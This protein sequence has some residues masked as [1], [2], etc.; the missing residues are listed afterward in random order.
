MSGFS[1]NMQ[2]LSVVLVL[3]IIA[4]AS[5]IVGSPAHAQRR[6]RRESNANRKARIER[7]IQETYSH[8]YELFGGG[9]YLRFRSGEYLQRNNEVTWATSGTYF[10][11]PKLGITADVRGGYGDAKVGNTVYNIANPLITEYTILGGVTYRLYMKQKFAISIN[12][13]AG[14]SLGNFDGGSKGVP[15]VNLGMWATSNRPAFSAGAS[16]DYNFYPNFAFRVMP[17]YVGTTF[18]GQNVINGV[19][20]GVS[21]GSVQNNL[22]VNAGIIYRFGKIK[23]SK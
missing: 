6:P 14:Y 18:H 16:F 21:N 19:P 17:T 9:G 12:G 4:I 20:T 5:I 15:A 13:L 1:K 23:P 3:S 22:G 7:T 11:N 2:R 8:R 10:L